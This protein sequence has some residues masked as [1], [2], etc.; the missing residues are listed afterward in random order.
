M[1]MKAPKSTFLEAHNNLY[2]SFLPA[3]DGLGVE[4]EKGFRALRK[5]T[6]HCSDVVIDVRASL[7]SLELMG[8]VVNAKK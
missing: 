2:L 6:Q 1:V 8:F 4:S 7:L 5:R 3:T